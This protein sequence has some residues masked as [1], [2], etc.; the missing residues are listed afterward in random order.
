MG[1][2]MMGGALLGGV[3]AVGA[4]GAGLLA[5]TLTKGF[6]RLKTIDDAK[7]K[8]KALGNTAADVDKIMQSA[9]ASVKGTAYG[10]GDAATI[11][12]SAVAAGVKP[13]EEL[14]KY[15]TLT[16]DAA[17]VAGTS[18]GDMGRIINQVRTSGSAYTE[19]L[20][21]LADRGVPIYQWLGE[22]AGVAAGDVK[23]LAA[24]GKISSQMLESAISKH[25]GGAAK[26]MGASFS[27][28]V[29][30]AQAALGR[31]GEALLKPVFGSAAGG[32]TAITDAL[33]NVTTWI[34]NNQGLIAT[35]W[36]GLGTFAIN[37]AQSTLQAVGDITVGIGE[38]VG[39]IGNTWGTLLKIK[40]AA[41]RATGDGAEADRLTKESEAAYGW[42]ESIKAAGEKIKGT[43]QSMDGARDRLSAWGSD[44]RTTADTLAKL[45]DNAGESSTKIKEAF[46][47]LPTNVPVTIETPGGPEAYDLL[48]QLG[49]EVSVN[50][51]KQITVGAPLAPEILTT[52]KSL[53]FEVTQN[54]DKTISVKQV[55]A[56]AAGKQ[57]DDA[58]NKERTASISVIAK[59]GEGIA[60]DPGIQ[61]QFTNDFRNA[62][63]ASAR[64]DGAIV[65]MA[66]GGLRAIDKPQQ[67]DIYDGVGAGTVFAEEE[68]GGEAYIPLAPSKRERSTAILA[69]VAKMFGLTLSSPSGSSG[70][71]VSGG[72]SV[73]GSGDIVGSLKSAV[74]DPIVSALD[75][76]RQALS[77]GGGS[78]YS[79]GSSVYGSDAALLAM[80][81]KGGRYDSGGDL[82][83]GLADCTSGIEDLVNMMDGKST[84]GRSMATGNAAEWLSAHGFLP[85]G[86]PVPGAFNVGYNSHHMEGTLPG[87]TNVN[88][89]SDSAVASGGTAGAAGAWGDTSFTQHYYRAV[90]ALSGGADSWETLTTATGD[91][92]AAITARTDAETQI[93]DAA[94]QQA[95]QKSSGGPDGSSFGQ[96]L[97]SGML[98]GIGLD[99]SVFSNPLEWPNVK[100]AMALANWGGGM[101]QGLAGGPAGSTQPIQNQPNAAHAGTG[102]APGPSVVVNGNIGMNPRDFTQRVDAAQNQSVRRNLAAVRPA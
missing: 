15:L 75:N 97:V 91:L 47:Q 1:A 39:G 73:S 80:V 71:T 12:A 68:T 56:E 61:R 101:L 13:G 32:V 44:A 52:L 78:R 79:G 62:F 28:S 81:P 85:T 102:A 29:E 7:F 99:G 24:D 35:F 37:A 22:E 84:A 54:N 9:Q 66:N 74:T 88:F 95:E 70:S 5:A 55:G 100:S 53:G 40:A 2:K 89:G 10:M 98:Q 77:S 16:A 82:S 6:D 31:L 90:D 45:G 83:K 42:G 14:T 34:N 58:A 46:G 87:G 93:T 3:A 43:A 20:N 76:I 17:A 8:L 63:G 69:E 41:S 18:L 11:A 59:Y 94:T 38:L 23:K 19:D 92:N 72:S 27:G 65:P 33:N 96:S 64:A 21:Q 51:D 30:N 49:A 25:I 48:K 86:K 36:Q 4:A 26:T 60:T 57:I 67:A 50:N